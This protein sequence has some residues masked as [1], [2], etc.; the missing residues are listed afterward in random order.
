MAT[1]IPI[2]GVIGKCEPFARGVV[3]EEKE[4]DGCQ[5]LILEA[6]IWIVNGGVRGFAGIR[7]PSRRS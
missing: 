3:D 1:P 2:P 6:G 4:S 5:D 7:L